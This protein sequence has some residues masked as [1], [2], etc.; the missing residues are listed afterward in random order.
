MDDAQVILQSYTV[1]GNQDGEPTVQRL[2]ITSHRDIVRSVVS[3]S[4][5]FS[6]EADMVCGPSRCLTPCPYPLACEDPFVFHGLN[7]NEPR[8]KLNDYYTKKLPGPLL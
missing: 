4:G 2:T 7:P 5:F 3:L 1:T 6:R 8:S